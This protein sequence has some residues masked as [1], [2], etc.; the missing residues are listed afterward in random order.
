MNHADRAR[1]TT[2]I[3]ALSVVSNTVLVALKLVVGLTIG[4]VAV[5][6]EAVHS[7]MDL[8]AAVIALFA[9]RAAARPADDDHP[10]GHGKAE[11]IS[12]TV[13]ALLI[14]TAA[15]WII[16]EAGRKLMGDHEVERLDWGVGVMALSAIVNLIVSELLF[17]TA[18]ETDSVA[19]EADGWHLRTDVYTSVGVV[20]ALSFIAFTEAHL[21]A[22]HA[23]WVDPVAAIVVALLIIQ[24]AWHLTVNSA[25]D[26]MDVALPEHEERAIRSALRNE[27]PDVRGFH[28]LR[29]RKAGSQRFVDVHVLVDPQ[30]TVARSHRLT[31]AVEN[32]IG[33]RLPRTAVVVHIEPCESDCCGRCGPNCLVERAP[34]AALPET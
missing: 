3:A 23:H 27:I 28:K 13:E 8:V 29:T 12:G 20:G 14:F 10:Y 16:W 31:E 26:L 19:L 24:A 25:R 7:G 18:R 11:N 6:S 9:V 32:A 2:R 22:L 30:M 17:R 21:T 1:K 5:I 15:A 4:S 33:D 34:D